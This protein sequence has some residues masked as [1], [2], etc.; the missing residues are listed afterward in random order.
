MEWF[1]NTVPVVAKQPVAGKGRDFLFLFP[2]ELVHVVEVLVAYP[3]AWILR[4]P[5]FCPLP[6]LV[7]KSFVTPEIGARVVVFFSSWDASLV[8][9]HTT[10]C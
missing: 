6:Y 9:S 8:L 7:S 2:G 10:C 3:L 1:V 5:C 4:M